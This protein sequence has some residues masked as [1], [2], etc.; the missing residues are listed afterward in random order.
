MD[1]RIIVEDNP[2]VQ[3]ANRIQGSLD[4][5]HQG[6]SLLPPLAH[7]ERRH[8]ASCAMLALER[9]V[10]LVQDGLDEIVDHGFV[11]RKPCRVRKV[12]RKASVQVSVSRVSENDSL[13]S[14]AVP[15]EHGAQG[16]HALCQTRE[17]KDQILL[18]E[19]SSRCTTLPQARIHLLPHRPIGAVTLGIES[20][21]RAIQHR[22]PF[23]RTHHRIA[24]RAAGCTILGMHIQQQKSRTSVVGA[25]L[26]RK[27]RDML[28][29]AKGFAVGDLQRGNALAIAQT[30][31]R[32]TG[33][34]HIGKEQDARSFVASVRDRAVARLADKGETAFRAHD[35]VFQHVDR[36]VVVEQ[37]VDPVAHGVFHL[38]LFDH[39]RAQNVVRCKILG[40]RAQ[41]FQQDGVALAKVVARFL[42]S[43]IE[44]R[45][46]EQDESQRIDRLIAVLLCPAAHAAG[47]VGDDSADLRACNGCRI[48]SYLAS[49]RGKRGVGSPARR[50]G[51][52]CDVRSFF[53]NPHLSPIGSIE[54]HQHRI[55]DR[56]SG[57]TGAACAKGD[58]DAVSTRSGKH[59][60]HLVLVAHEHDEARQQTIEGGV[61][62]HHLTREA[63]LD[64]AFGR[65]GSRELFVETKLR[66]VAAACFLFPFLFLSVWSFL[67]LPC[68][69][70]CGQSCHE[71]FFFLR[72]S[73]TT[74]PS[75]ASFCCRSHMAA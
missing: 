2:R 71:S 44:D 74:I 70:L 39:T 23:E 61:A 19:K 46:V 69:F 58:S 54:L 59:G 65:Q 10:E 26:R 6:E 72:L 56:L 68:V 14:I 13:L 35:K 43:R 60:L 51:T 18:H 5:L 36:I 4:A 57:K 49:E 52:E 42:R 3:N 9:A 47:V 63:V 30:H 64:D 25:R 12:E 17:R 32:L 22:K 20:K 27:V 16:K 34:L 75:S 73:A 33:A 21:I 8:V 40:N 11:T 31:D 37:G 24:T 53:G 1:G 50:A 28:H 62:A 48:G 45:S 67:F 38:V 29:A 41:V 66:C 15:V 7:D 55:G